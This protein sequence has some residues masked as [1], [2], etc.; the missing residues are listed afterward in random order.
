M[1]DRLFVI[2]GIITVPI[3]LVG[4]VIF[5]G[6]PQGK[7]I[8]WM[9]EDEQLLAQERMRTDGVAAARPLTFKIFIDIFKVRLLSF[10]A[11]IPFAHS[12]VH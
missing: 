5:P 8:W 12:I 2:D 11:T 7:R 10:S 6:L 3:A 4:F 1:R 9:R